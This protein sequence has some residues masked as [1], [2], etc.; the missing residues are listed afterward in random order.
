VT[1]DIKCDGC[2]AGLPLVWHVQ[3]RRQV[4]LNG[5]ITERCARA[6]AHDRRARDIANDQVIHIL[7]QEGQ[8]YGSE[9][10]CCNRCGVMIWGASAPAYVDNWTDYEASPNNCS[11]AKAR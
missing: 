10:R 9:R 2:K 11:K 4:H 6:D 3:S 5:L 8:P 7:S 1:P